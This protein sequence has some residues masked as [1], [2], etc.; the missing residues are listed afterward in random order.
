[1]RTGDDHALRVT[2]PLRAAA[3]RRENAAVATLGGGA[4]GDVLGKGGV[5]PDAAVGAAAA[6]GL[7]H[8]LLNEVARLGVGDAASPLVLAALA[9]VLAAGLAALLALAAGSA[10]SVAARATVS[11]TTV[12]VATPAGG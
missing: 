1:A 2:Q 5:E 9:A 10:V 6:L 12:A 4:E 11:R 3:A 7:L 8:P